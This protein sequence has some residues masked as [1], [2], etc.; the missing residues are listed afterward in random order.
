MDPLKTLSG[1]QARQRA[2][3]LWDEFKSFA[4]KGSVIDLAV[5]IIIGAAFTKIVDSLVKQ[6]FMPLLGLVTPGEH[7]YAGWKVTIK[8]AE[9][10]YGQFLGEVVN[11][12]LVAV[13]LFVFIRKFL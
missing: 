3:T 5:G 6:I 12:L 10:L 2:S 4:F 9:I 8:G 1:L 7:G 11:F 13:L